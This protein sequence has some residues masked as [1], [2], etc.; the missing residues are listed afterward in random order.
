MRLL[1]WVLLAFA[2]MAAPPVIARPGVTVTVS[3]GPG[4][5]WLIDYAFAFRSRIWFFT[6]SNN[7]LDGKPWR[8]QSWTIE[9]PGVRLERVGRYD[10]LAGAAPLAKVRIRMHPF[11]HPLV[12]DYTPVL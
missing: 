1:R 10:V 3:R 8:P 11:A 4:G 2:L 5:D 9:T 12:A 6:R 7:D